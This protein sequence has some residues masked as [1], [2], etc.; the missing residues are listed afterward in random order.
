MPSD[1][2]EDQPRRLHPLSFLFAV[3]ARIKDFA[4]PLVIAWLFPLR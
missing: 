4:L 2:V 3:G 1:L